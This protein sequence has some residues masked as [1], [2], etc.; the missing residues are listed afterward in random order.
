MMEDSQH[1]VALALKV[2]PDRLDF[3][4]RPRVDFKV[5]LRPSFRMA[6]L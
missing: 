2:Q 1:D 4:F 3:S 6:T 5:R